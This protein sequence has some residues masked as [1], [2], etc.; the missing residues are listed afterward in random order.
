MSLPHGRRMWGW[1]V[2]ALMLPCCGGSSTTQTGTLTITAP[3]VVSPT[4]IPADFVWSTAADLG[5]WANNAVSRNVSVLSEDGIAFIRVRLGPDSFTL[6]SPDLP[7]DSAPIT[8]I[9]IVYRWQ[10]SESRHALN[11]FLTTA[12][13]GR[14]SRPTTRRCRRWTSRRRRGRER[15]PVL[16]VRQ[17]CRSSPSTSTSLRSLRSH[18]ERSTSQR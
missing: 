14:S 13:R 4:P 1:V 12:V 2:V 3:S 10:P 8:G 6:R 17:D 15:R 5:A 7:H 9:R 11:V 16:S 18:Q